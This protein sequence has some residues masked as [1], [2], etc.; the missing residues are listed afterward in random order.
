M[1]TLSRDQI[2][3]LLVDA[4]FKKSSP[5]TE[6]MIAIAYAESS[7]DPTKHN[8][9]PSTKDDSY[10]LWQINMIGKLGP[11]RRKKFGIT[12]NTQLL[13]PKTNAKAAYI[14]YKDSGLDAWSTYKRGDYLKFMDSTSGFEQGKDTE[15]SG[16]P[17]PVAGVEGAINAFG[18]TV[19]KGISNVAGVAVAI[20]LLVLGIILLSR[21]QLG[22]ILPAGKA[23]KALKA[24]V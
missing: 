23:A 1:S 8:D 21:K 19:F 22:N 15:A 4:G 13:D 17:N 9:N 20:T 10:G 14:I 12:S 3:Q 24:V 7:G 6:T 16:I 5:D 11:D 18:D 2:R